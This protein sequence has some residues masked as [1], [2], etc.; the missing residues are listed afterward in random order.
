MKGPRK[1]LSL[2]QVVKE[3]E[4]DPTDLYVSGVDVGAWP[5]SQPGVGPLPEQFLINSPYKRRRRNLRE[6]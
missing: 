4:L 2:A 5:F 3:Q 1:G 6:G